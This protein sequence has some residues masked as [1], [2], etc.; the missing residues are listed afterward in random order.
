MLQPFTFEVL[1]SE[2]VENP[3]AEAGRDQLV[4]LAH[5]TGGQQSACAP[6][7][8][9]MSHLRSRILAPAYAQLPLRTVASCL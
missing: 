5:S 7:V 8:S 9:F 4:A 6:V 3:V 2:R 1:V